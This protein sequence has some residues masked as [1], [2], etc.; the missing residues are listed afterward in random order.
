MGSILA[1][2]FGHVAL[3]QIKKGHES[4]SEGG[5]GIAIAGVVFG[6]VGIGT[7]VAVIL[8]FAVVAVQGQPTSLPR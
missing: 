8:L 5:R 7:A 4:E 3:S 6:W 1:V 2:I